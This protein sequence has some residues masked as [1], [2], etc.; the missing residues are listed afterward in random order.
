MSTDAIT[1]PRQRMIDNMTA[2]HLG[3]HTQQAYVR[4]GKRF[5][6]FIK[7]SPETATADDIRR[8]QVDLAGSGISIGNRNGIVTGVKFLFRC[9]GMT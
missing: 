9:A 8:F 1:L 3:S 6:A 7:R 5:A 2:R 4:S